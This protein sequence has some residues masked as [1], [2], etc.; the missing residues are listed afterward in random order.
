[1]LMLLSSVIVG[2]LYLVGLPVAP[3]E[4][5]SPLIV[6]P[7]AV[8]TFPV[9]AQNLEAVARDGAQLVETLCRMEHLELPPGPRDEPMVDAPHIAALEQRRRA[10]VS[11]APDHMVTYHVTMKT[12]S[13]VIMMAAAGLRAL[14]SAHLGSER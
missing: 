9:P 3:S 12:P 5:D 6:D 13:V 11:E 8:L 14:F 7:D 2:E 1:M 4:T 10:S